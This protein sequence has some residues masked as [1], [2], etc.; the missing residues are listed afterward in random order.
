MR[1]GYQKFIRIFMT[2][3]VFDELIDIIKRAPSTTLGPYEKSN[4]TSEYLLK[5]FT[6]FLSPDSYDYRSDLNPIFSPR[7][8]LLSQGLLEQVPV[9]S[10]RDGVF[11]LLRFFSM[12]PTPLQTMPLLVIDQ[13]LSPL[14]PEVWR[15]RVLLRSLYEKSEESKR[16]DHKNILLFLSPDKCTLPLEYLETELSLITSMLSPG[17]E[18]SLFFSSVKLRGEGDAYYDKAW[19]LKILQSLLSKMKDFKI[20]VLDWKEYQGLDL[21]RYD[22]YFL[23]PLRF[24]F[25]DSYLLH[26][27]LARGA[28]A[29]VPYTKGPENSYL[30]D[31]SLNHGFILH[32]Q[33][34]AFD[35]E[36][37]EMTK[38]FFS[39][40]PSIQNSGA[41]SRE[42][43]MFL[44]EDFRD[45]SLDVA[46]KLYK[47][48]TLPQVPLF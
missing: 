24:Y 26:D 15:S 2:S 46:S 20:T 6:E 14:V 41:V 32:H 5:R 21:S 7:I 42:S 13:D 3:I 23:N 34:L 8:E 27:V 45:W 4:F 33:F 43:L 11:P 22:Y 31:L 12:N 36:V 10:L 39:S 47:D 25:T 9:F 28:R 35:L 44:R 38:R 48:R 17:D 37:D 30:F 16:G 29:L 18:L 40:L 1:A 19:G